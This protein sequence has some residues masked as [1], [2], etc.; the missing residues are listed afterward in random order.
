MKKDRIAALLFF[1]LSLLII[2][3]LT[4]NTLL[5]APAAELDPFWN[6]S[7]EA[8]TRTVDHTTLD[9]FLLRY[10]GT[11]TDGIARIAYEQVT[12]KDKTSLQSY[13]DRLQKTPVLSLNRK[14]QFAFWVNL[15]NAATLDLILDYTPQSSIKE[16]NI[17]PG[18]FSVGPWKKDLLTVEG[19]P[20]SLD[21]I[22]HSILRPIWQDARVHYVVNCASLGCPDIPEQALNA[23]R[24][25]QQLDAAARAFINHPRGVT[26]EDPETVVISSL[27]NWF[28]EDFGQDETEILDHIRAFADPSLKQKLKNITAIE[29]YRYDWSLNKA[30]R[31][32]LKS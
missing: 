11:G 9:Q 3:G 14:Q 32:D 12:S 22:E 26:L 28:S 20:V 19:K 10:R 7:D 23:E 27:Y 21:R 1:L 16:I 24:L 25:E 5:A 17:S 2:Q 31:S 15:Y 29:G 30:A 13:L 18:F 6:R 4:V 8:S